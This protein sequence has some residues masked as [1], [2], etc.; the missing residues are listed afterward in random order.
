MLSKLRNHKVGEAKQGHITP[1]CVEFLLIFRILSLWGPCLTDIFFCRR[2]QH[3]R[4][5]SARSVNSRQSSFSF[6]FRFSFLIFASCS[7]NRKLGE[8]GEINVTHLF[9]A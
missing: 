3:R 2:P 6:R 4:R 7:E 1:R 8:V 5:R 9:V